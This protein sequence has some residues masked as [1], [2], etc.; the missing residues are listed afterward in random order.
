MKAVVKTQKAP[1]AELLEMPLPEIKPDEALIKIKVA[2]ICGT[3]VHIYNW[4]SA[5]Q[6]YIKNVPQILGHEFAGEIVKTGKKVKKFRVGDY[7]SAETHFF[8]GKCAQCRN[9][10]R[11]ICETEKGK[12]FGLSCDGCFAEYAAVPERILWKNNP[13]LA[14]EIATLQ[15][16]LGNAVYCALGDY[17]KNL[18]GKKVLIFGDGPA[19]LLAAGVAKAEGARFVTLVGR[20]QKRLEIAGKIGA[21][22]TLNEK[23]NNATELLSQ[24][25]NIGKGF[26]VALEMA[27]S[28]N[29]RDLAIKSV[30][31][32]GRLSLF[33]IDTDPFI[34]ENSGQYVR[35]A[36]KII[37]ITGR[38]IWRTWRETKRLLE[39]G[40]LDITPVI[41]HK[42][43]LEEF[44]KG[45]RAMTERPKVSGKVI[46]IP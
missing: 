34:I 1:G 25:L 27:G 30:R 4:D 5:A 22:I 23:E 26:D 18:K 16:P 42:F 31:D 45:F 24:L 36:K 15:E 39:S 43:P 21:D 2:S 19:G 20:H 17:D 40:L 35:S 13:R 46:L 6:V 8:C 41:T 10:Q 44:E 38:L 29:A 14:P 28:K 33:G 9:G 11:H 12:I 37:P 7:V 32:G 3:D